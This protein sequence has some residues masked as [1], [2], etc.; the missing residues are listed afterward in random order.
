MTISRLRRK[1]RALHDESEDGDSSELNLVP[2]LD[3]VTNII[4]FLM[5]TVSFS[6]ALAD[7]KVEAPSIC[8]DEQAPGPARAPLLL[9]VHV[10]REGW[11]VLSS[12]GVLARPSDRAALVKAL[13]QIKAGHRDETHVVVS[14]D[15]AI[16]YDD[17]I[18]TLDAARGDADAPLFPDATLA[19]GLQ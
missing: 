3:I 12:G 8:C 14:A 9:T 1:K 15:P 10:S 2:Y 11:V 6:A 7:V 4:L 16:P 17:V 19:A 18:T 13:A 5:M